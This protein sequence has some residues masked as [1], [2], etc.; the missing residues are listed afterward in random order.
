MKNTIEKVLLAGLMG[1]IA[2]GAAA[3]HAIQIYLAETDA[4]D[5]VKAEPAPADDGSWTCV[6]GHAGNT[7]NFCAEC[8]SPRPAEEAANKCP[9]CGNEFE[10][11][12]VPRFCPN[13]GT[14]LH[15]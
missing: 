12:N 11:G 9:N 5:P 8:G 1:G 4:Q 3:Y 10:A 2:L 15:D 14:K 6:N 13:C 7:G